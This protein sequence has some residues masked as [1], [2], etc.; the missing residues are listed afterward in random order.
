MSIFTTSLK[1]MDYRFF[2]KID[3]REFD[4]LLDYNYKYKLKS[5]QK[6]KCKLIG[7]YFNKEI[8]TCKL[9]SEASTRLKTASKETPGIVCARCIIANKSSLFKTSKDS[10]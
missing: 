6:I 5:Y 8:I 7:Y 10:L 4:I 9:L 3:D 2:E 1:A